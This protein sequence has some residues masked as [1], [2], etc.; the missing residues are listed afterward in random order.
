[1]W[2]RIVPCL[3]PSYPPQEQLE[4]LENDMAKHF[5]QNSGGE[6]NSCNPPP[7][8]VHKH[9]HKES[10]S[11]HTK[12]V[13]QC[14]SDPLS[15]RP[16]VPV[17]LP[18]ED[19]LVALRSVEEDG[20]TYWYRAKVLSL[21][22]QESRVEVK[23]LDY[24]NTDV[25]EMKDVMLLPSKFYRLQFQAVHCCLRGLSDFLESPKIFETFMAY[26]DKPALTAKVMTRYV[27]E[28]LV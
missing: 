1:M 13:T 14:S 20:S 15:P 17:E 3:S 9:T 11:T 10:A 12:R 8:D 4:A 24:G 2:V 19:S 28:E 16:A 22:P 23:L 6:M 26:Q 7:L 27:C 18:Q 25:V 5:A 21:L